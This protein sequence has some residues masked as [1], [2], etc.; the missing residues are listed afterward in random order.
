MTSVLSVLG[1]GVLAGAGGGVLAAGFGFLIAEPVIDRAI[2]FEANRSHHEG[3][4]AAAELFTRDTQHL[5]LLVAMIASGI[6]IGVLFSLVYVALHREDPQADPWRRSLRLAGAGFLAVVAMPFLRY[7]ANPPGVGDPATV[8]LRTRSW[9]A[10]IAIGVLAI[11]VAYAAGRWLA[12]RGVTEPLR[13]LAAAGIVV[14]GFG[15]LFLLP[16]NPDPI[17]VPAQL[18]WDFRLLSAATLLLLWSG[19]GAGFGLLGGYAA[20]RAVA[21]PATA[22]A[23]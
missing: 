12:R 14:A 4:E 17:E 2:E 19:I 10:A 7:P 23:G 16:D 18:L 9:L 1:R 13:H 20:R 8:E 22:A 21:A 3:G 5:G 15:V 11:A 6:A